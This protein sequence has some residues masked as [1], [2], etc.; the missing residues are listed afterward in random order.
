[1]SS[2]AEPGPRERLVHAAQRLSYT[3]GA[4]I[5]V[6]ALLKAANVARRSLYEHFGGKDGLIAEVLRRSA[7]EDEADYRAVF[8]A[9]GDDPRERLL[10][11][12]DRLGA[13]VSTP[14]F[15]G[16]RYLAADLAL[17]DS[18]HPAHAVTREYRERIRQLLDH[19]VRRLGHPDPGRATDQ[20]QL[21]IEGVLAIGATRPGAKH[22]E[23]AREL[24]KQV[25]DV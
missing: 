7:A 14:D 10:A 15:R 18:A 4:T 8:A 17:A 24:A 13:V 25:L 23:S 3:H 1:M 16:C 5:G 11:V 19:E 20:L 6:D 22:A 9:A 2:R 12:F 21:L